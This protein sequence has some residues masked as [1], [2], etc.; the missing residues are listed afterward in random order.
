M[1]FTSPKS[2]CPN[3][4]L[5]TVG[6]FHVDA[7]IPVAVSPD[8]NHVYAG[9]FTDDAVVVF[10]RNPDTGLLTFVDMEKDGVGGVEGLDGVDRLTL[11]PDPRE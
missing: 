10:S 1:T 3:L 6:G 4:D 2:P 7:V 9:G 8:G 5:G 11:S